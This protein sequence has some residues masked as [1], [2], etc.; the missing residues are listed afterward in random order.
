MGKRGQNGLAFGFCVS[1]E[2][3]SSNWHRFPGTGQFG[4]PES[5]VLSILHDS[6]CRQILA[7]AGGG[8]RT[9]QSPSLQKER[10]LKASHSHSTSASGWRRS[11]ATSQL[12]PE[13][14]W[15]R[16][17]VNFYRNAWTAEPTDKM[18]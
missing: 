11:P 14:K 3:S 17:V 4:Q 5:P 12:L 18:K 15:E 10:R 7:S 8:R 9:R 6:T 1:R 16:R 2:N 13:A